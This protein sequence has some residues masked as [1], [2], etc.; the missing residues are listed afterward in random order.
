MGLCSRRVVAWTATVRTGALARTLLVIPLAL[1]ASAV[2]GGAKDEQALR[3]LGPDKKLGI[4]EFRLRGAAIGGKEKATMYF[5]L[6]GSLAASSEADTVTPY[7]Q[8][9]G[10]EFMSAFEKALADTGAFELAPA[11]G[12]NVMAKG[13]A[14]PLGEAAASNG[15]FACVKAD[16]VLGIAVGWKK[17]VNVRTEWTF[18]GPA[19]WEF[20]ITTKATS[21][22]AQ[23]MFPDTDDPALGPVFVQ[24]ARDSARLL[25]EELGDKMKKAGS[26]AEIRLLAP[27]AVPAATEHAPVSADSTATPEP[28]TPLPE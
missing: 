16:A 13:K 28:P 1:S 7:S 27:E 10:T 22:E 25:L 9:M 6:L 19:G 20:D 21:E 15:L 8:E 26:P 2:W 14:R 11:A 23:G 5:G 4:C 18:A 24:L 3:E 12:L 17:K